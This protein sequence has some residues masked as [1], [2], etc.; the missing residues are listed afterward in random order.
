MTALALAVNR[1][2][3]QG[4]ALEG[5]WQEADSRIQETIQVARDYQDPTG[6][7]S[8]HYF[9]RPGRSAD[10]DQ[11]LGTTGH[12]LEYLAMSATDRQLREP[13]MRRAAE[14]LCQLFQLTRDVPLE[15]GGL[16]HAAHGLIIYRQRV[17][18]DPATRSPKGQMTRHL[19]DPR[20]VAD[21]GHRGP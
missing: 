6:A 3:A 12:M 2:L 18:G 13:W 17:F 9:Q 7:F 21:R 11:T 16:Y 5:E 1:Y 20:T 4:H 14:R 8:V 19:R 10:L 15:C